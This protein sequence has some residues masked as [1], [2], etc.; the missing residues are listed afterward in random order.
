MEKKRCFKCQDIKPVGQFFLRK[1]SPDGYRNCCKE[2]DYLRNKIRRMCRPICSVK[3]CENRQVSKGL[4]EHHLRKLRLY[5]RIDLPGRSDQQEIRIEGDIALISLRDSNGM[6]AA[7]AIIDA[8]DVEKV[9]HYTWSCFKNRVNCSVYLS[10]AGKR[11]NWDKIIPI[12]RLLMNPPQNRIILHR[13]GNTMDNRKTNLV[14]V[15]HTEKAINSKV[16]STSKSGVRGVSFKKS[17]EKWG[18]ILIRRGVTYYGGYF[19]DIQDA[20]EARKRLEDVYFRGLFRKQA[21]ENSTVI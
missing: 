12:S 11:G 10:V 14:L 17:I 13:N 7:E 6:K 16:F 15:D 18:A 9:S 3:N 21:A 19:E 1:N 20:I 2:C 4:C 5:G 8:E